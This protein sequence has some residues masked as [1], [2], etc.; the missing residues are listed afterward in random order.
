[1]LSD[2]NGGMNQLL[3]IS[4]NYFYSSE[5]GTLTA[6]DIE[7]RDIVWEFSQPGVSSYLYAWENF[8]GLDESTNTIYGLH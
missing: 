5:D 8:I 1:M 2:T 6:R 3:A 4:T 7:T